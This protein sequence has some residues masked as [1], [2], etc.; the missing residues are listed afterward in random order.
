M[1][2]IIIITKIITALITVMKVVLIHFLH[3]HSFLCVKGK[4]IQLQTWIGP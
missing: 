3:L 4:A 1:F 2:I